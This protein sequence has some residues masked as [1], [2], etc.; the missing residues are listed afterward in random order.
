[1]GRLA[2]RAR[3]DQGDGVAVALRHVPTYWQCHAA[4]RHT[5]SHPYSLHVHVLYIGFQSFRSL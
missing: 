2:R 5:S 3:M 4:K 1:M